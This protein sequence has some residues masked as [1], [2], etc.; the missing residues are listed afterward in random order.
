MRRSPGRTCCVCTLLWRPTQQELKEILVLC[1]EHSLLY[2]LC[3]GQA[4]VPS[5]AACPAS[6]VRQADSPALPTSQQ[7]VLL[8]PCTRR[9]ALR[10]TAHICP[11]RKASF[12]VLK[13]AAQPRPLCPAGA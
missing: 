11:H 9:T 7:P 2:S 1:S 10:C 5:S 6:A 8:Q 3:A 4:A 13:Q 12:S